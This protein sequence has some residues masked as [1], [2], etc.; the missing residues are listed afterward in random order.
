MAR[1]CTINNE[2]QGEFFIFLLVLKHGISCF[3]QGRDW[4]LLA[5]VM[6]FYQHLW[7]RECRD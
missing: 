6:A 3:M 2:N 5:K 7:A 1:V 4:V